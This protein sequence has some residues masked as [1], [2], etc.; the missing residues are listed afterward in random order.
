MTEKLFTGTLNKNKKKKNNNFVK[1]ARRK[2]KQNSSCLYGNDCATY[3]LYPLLKGLTWYW[4]MIIVNYLIASGND[5]SNDMRKPEFCICVN[6]GSD[7]LQSNHAAD[8]YPCFHQKLHKSEISC[9]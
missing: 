1:N 9:L 6:T 3:T 2:R 4:A 8:Q 7:Q 5:H